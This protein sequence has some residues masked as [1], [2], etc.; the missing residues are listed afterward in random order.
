MPQVKL[1]GNLRQYTGES[2]IIQPG[3]TVGEVLDGLV[4][5]YP[6][7]EPAIF[8]HGRLNPHIICLVM[9]R[10]INLDAGMG[11]AVDDQESIAIFPPIGGGSKIVISTSRIRLCIQRGDNCI[12]H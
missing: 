3:A 12:N 8:E 1:F 10:N 2:V 5:R 9:G 7:L 11:T 4:A 6:A